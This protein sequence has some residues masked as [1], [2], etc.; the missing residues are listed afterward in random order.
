MAKIS[1]YRAEKIIV[2]ML[3]CGVLT[4]KASEKGIKYALNRNSPGEEDL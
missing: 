2:N 4:M 3:L 1:V